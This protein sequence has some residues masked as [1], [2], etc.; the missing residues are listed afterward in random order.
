MAKW[1]MGKNAVLTPPAG[2]I[3]DDI[4]DAEI[5]CSGDELDVTVFGDTEM[6]VQPGLADVTIDLVV[7]HHTT[8]QGAVSTIT[9]ASLS[10][11]PVV[12]TNIDSKVSPK[13]RWEHTI[14]YATTL[15]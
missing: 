14:S 13:G 8:S 12:V 2:V 1:K 11:H 3:L 5:S 6:K 4:V 15:E 9:I 10:D 7:T